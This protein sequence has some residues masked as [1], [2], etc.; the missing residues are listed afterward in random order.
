MLPIVAPR[1]LR[2]L[3]PVQI[4]R[5]VERLP[6]LVVLDDPVHELLTGL[7]VGLVDHVERGRQH[8][9]MGDDL[10]V[11]PLAWFGHRRRP[12]LLDLGGIEPAVVTG[13]LGERR[14]VHEPLYSRCGEDAFLAQRLG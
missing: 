12:R 1:M 6:R 10:G 2:R 4:D 11:E 8:V 9:G 14:G 13:E 7:P 3:L 5:H